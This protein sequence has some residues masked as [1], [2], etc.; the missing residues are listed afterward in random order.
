MNQLLNKMEET[1]QLSDEKRLEERLREEE[2]VAQQMEF[3]QLKE[4]ALKQARKGKEKIREV[5]EDVMEDANEPTTST[6]RQRILIS[7]R[8]PPEDSTSSLQ[9][10]N[11]SQELSIF[12]FAWFLLILFIIWKLF[13]WILRQL[14]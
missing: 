14:W 1:K 3:E 9:P 5:M 7:E 8:I 4:K 12:H 10:S 6:I 13:S 11:E 2:A